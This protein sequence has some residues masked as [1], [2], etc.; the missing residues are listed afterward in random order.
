[1]KRVGFSRGEG[2]ENPGDSALLWP[3]VGVESPQNTDWRPD[4][5]EQRRREE[6]HRSRR[7]AAGYATEPRAEV[8]PIPVAVGPGAGVLSERVK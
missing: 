3:Q 2:E 1:M 8:E 5:G 4:R 7:F 6:T